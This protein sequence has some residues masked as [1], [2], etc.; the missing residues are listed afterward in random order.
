MEDGGVLVKIYSII[1]VALC[2]LLFPSVSSALLLGPYSGT[3]IDSQT[4]EPVEGASVLIYWTKSVFQMIH[5]SSELID[6]KLVYTDGKGRYKIPRFFANIGLLSRFESTNVI[7]YQPGYQAYMVKIW[8]DSPYSK[9]DPSFK[10]KDNTVKL[11]RIP[12]NFSHRKHHE[13]IEHALWGIHDYPYSYPQPEDKWMT[14]EKLIE[15]N[16]KTLVKDELLRRTEWE[17]RRGDLEDRR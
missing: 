13:N 15:I 8:H 12:P 17:K 6:A 2:V 10:E 3:V 16:L 4:G 1:F 9:P 11:D 7:I 5:S 14:W